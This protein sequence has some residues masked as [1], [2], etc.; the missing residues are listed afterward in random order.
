M[1]PDKMG[2]SELL[3]EYLMP[4]VQANFRRLMKKVEE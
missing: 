2:F 4:F 3:N 1:L